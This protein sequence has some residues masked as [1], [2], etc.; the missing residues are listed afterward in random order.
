M[1]EHRGESAPIP[2]MAVEVDIERDGDPLILVLTRS[3]GP[4]R[5]SLVVSAKGMDED[6]LRAV[7]SVIETTIRERHTPLTSTKEVRDV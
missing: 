6:Q 3:N 2:G 1:A 5:A 7:L 4:G